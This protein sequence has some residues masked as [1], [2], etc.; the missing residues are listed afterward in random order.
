MAIFDRNTVIGVI[1]TSIIALFYSY[2]IF[3]IYIL[4]LILV[5]I[6][7]YKWAVF[8]LKKLNSALKN[9]TV[10]VVTIFGLTILCEIWLQLYPHRLTGI[11]EVDI[12][13][14]FSDYTSRGY[15]TEDVFNKKKDVVRILGLGD[16]F[17][18]YLRDKK[19][20]YNDILQQQFIASGKDEIEIV[21]AGM[22]A[23]GPGYYW[24][25]LNKY[26]ELFQPD[27]VLM[28]FFVGNDFTE[29]D[30]SVYIGN[31]ISEP[32][33]LYKR[34]LG[35]DQFYHWRL[36]RLL[37][38]KYTRYREAQL[39]KEEAKRQPSQE[40]GTFSQAT[41]LEVE[42]KRSWMF[43]K[44]NR[45]LLNQQWRECSE[46]ILKMKDWCDRR[47]IKFVIAILPEQFQVDQA[48]RQ[49][50]LTKYNHIAEENLDLS[51]PD[52]LIVNFCR[53]HN[54]NCLD[55]LG[56]FQEQGKTRRLYILRDSHWNEAGN[57]LAADLIFEYLEKN[58]LLPPRPSTGRP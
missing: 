34:Y 5:I 6:F 15:L 8:D 56:Q 1:I 38:N 46:V 27:L 22:E 7:R 19:I 57:R 52:N 23:M 3:G 43:D 29:A 48:L 16:S 12:V 9:I 50:V 21:N 58:Q 4:A 49:A 14:E 10:S 20:N 44:N 13:G 17:S 28:G 45:E 11:D 37:K 39:R 41:F 40:V 18:V 26:G 35:Y 31:F 42:K 32:K 51:Y 25:I 24:H 2:I 36:Y 33:D 30:F 54:I 55:L 53:T 47:K